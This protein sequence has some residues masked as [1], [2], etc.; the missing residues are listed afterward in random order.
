MAL[1][2]LFLQLGILCICVG[3]TS[4]GGSDTIM[5]KRSI[6]IIGAGPAGLCAA[7]ELL[8]NGDDE[9]IVLEKSEMVGGISRTESYKGYHFDIGGH[10]FFT[11]N[12]YVQELW[13]D[14]LK[15]DFIK[16]PRLSRIFYKDKYYQYPIKLFDTFFNLGVLESFRI[17]ISFLKRSFSP[18]P[19]RIHLRN[20]LP[21]D[22]EKG[23]TG[24][25]L[26]PIRKRYGAFPVHPFNRTGRHRE[27]KGFPL[28]QRLR[29]HFLGQKRQRL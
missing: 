18:I 21:T 12:E 15:E 19:K 22:S 4:S 11:K 13:D 28:R 16:V 27:F 5:G 6:Y 14:I 20:G 8:K 1:V 2:L 9:V 17:L 26:K 23:F 24:L 25:F 10:R 3:K 29:M 7:N